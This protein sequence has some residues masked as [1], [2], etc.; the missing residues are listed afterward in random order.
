MVVL[1][2][3]KPYRQITDVFLTIFHKM[4]RNL[5]LGQLTQLLGLIFGVLRTSLNFSGFD[6]IRTC[7]SQYQFG[8]TAISLLPGTIGDSVYFVSW[9]HLVECHRSP[10]FFSF[11]KERL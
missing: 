11:F 5:F 4:K 7:T 9:R 3:F 6:G 1:E 2:I 8:S 10:K